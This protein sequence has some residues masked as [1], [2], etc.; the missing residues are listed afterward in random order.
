MVFLG[1]A[2][3]LLMGFI[4]GALSIRA[5]TGVA[6]EVFIAIPIVAMG[7]P[8]LDTLLA[9]VRRAADHRH[10]LLGDQDHIHHRLEVTGFGP[11]GLLV[12]VYGV[13]VLF[14]AGA[15]TL[16]FVH[17]FALEVA[18]LLG[19]LLLVVAVL[20]KLGYALSFW[21]SASVIW[22]RRRLRWSEAPAGERVDRD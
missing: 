9:V 5:T 14:A 22:L 16:H 6:D 4:L 8:I 1:D 7:F 19:T 12:V 17:I 15:I 3:A 10:P 18:V 20:T 2:G 13:S 21:N 11:R